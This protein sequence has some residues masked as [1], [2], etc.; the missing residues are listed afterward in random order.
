MEKAKP[1]ISSLGAD[2]VRV[3]KELKCTIQCKNTKQTHHYNFGGRPQFES[4]RRIISIF[5]WAC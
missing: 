3:L 4:M 1:T 5:A 2:E